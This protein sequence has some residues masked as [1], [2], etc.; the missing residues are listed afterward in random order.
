MSMHFTYSL[1]NFMEYMQLEKPIPVSTANSST[2][3][4]GFGTII[5]NCPDTTG[6]SMVR[7]TPVFYIPD[8]TSQLLFLGEFLQNGLSVHG[9]LQ[10]ISLHFSLGTIFMVFY[11]RALNDTI[12]CVKSLPKQDAMNIFP[13][14]FKLT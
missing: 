8:L 11:P 7:V 6:Q 1:D 10:H 4:M 14:I 2:V 3:V 5:L 9:D 12:Y 13:M